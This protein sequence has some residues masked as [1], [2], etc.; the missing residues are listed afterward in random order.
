MFS[1]YSSSLWSAVS[2]LT[3]LAVGNLWFTLFWVCSDFFCFCCLGKQEPNTFSSFLWDVDMFDKH[4]KRAISTQAISLI[5]QWLSCAPLM[6]QNSDDDGSTWLLRAWFPWW[7]DGDEPWEGSVHCIP[8]PPSSSSVSE[9]KKRMI[10]GGPQEASIGD[11]FSN[12]CK[13]GIL[14][15]QDKSK[16]ERRAVY[17]STRNVDSLVKWKKMAFILLT[18]V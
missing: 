3:R 14:I 10:S 4:I 12:C 7:R 8:L 5:L 18:T 6:L 15:S 9:R 16:L 2:K 13:C 1:E 11:C 17:W